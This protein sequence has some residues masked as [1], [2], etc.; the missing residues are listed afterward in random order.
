[1]TGSVGK[2]YSEAIF[3]LAAEQG[4]G[5][6]VFEELTSLRK[7]WTE[8]PGLAK[9]L[10]APT[11]SLKEKLGII[12]KSFKGR[13]SDIIYNFLCVITEKGRASSLTEIADSYKEK[14]YEKENIAE[15]TVTTCSPLSDA[16]RKKLVKKLEDVYKKKVV[17]E[18]K[19]DSSLIGGIVV[20]Y[21]NTMLDGSVKNRLDS[22][23]KQIKGIIA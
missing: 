1:M 3:E 12:E 18:E 10:S 14:W 5:G 13:V 22:I 20:N 9:L 4:C 8:N 6:Q 16:L 19:T 21:G 17:L 11:I 2:I 15:V 7:I 23:Q